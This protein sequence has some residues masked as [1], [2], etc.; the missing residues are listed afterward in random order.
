M[1]ADTQTS[2]CLVRL[3]SKSDTATLIKCLKGVAECVL[4]LRALEAPKR[5]VFTHLGGFDGGVSVVGESLQSI[6]SL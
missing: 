4:H 2:Q 3:F 1:S 5:E 6:K